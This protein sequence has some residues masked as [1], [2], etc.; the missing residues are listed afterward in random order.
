VL[1][2]C[3]ART[4]ASV[5][6]DKQGLPSGPEK[7][8]GAV[9][10][11]ELQSKRS[12]PNTR[13]QLGVSRRPL[14]NLQATEATGFSPAPGR[15]PLLDRIGYLRLGGYPGALTPT[16]NNSTASPPQLCT[17][18]A[19][20]CFPNGV[21]VSHCVQFL[22]KKCGNTSKF[23]LTLL[24][25]TL[26]PLRVLLLPSPGPRVYPLPARTSR[27]PRGGGHGHVLQYVIEK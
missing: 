12:N 9:E 1:F 8:R 7:S 25:H 3:P 23:C 15:Q 11:S 21:C 6:L 19:R 5:S 17:R 4:S 13:W 24:P 14:P 22:E 26:H 20:R 27:R 10:H 2:S 16:R 18:Y